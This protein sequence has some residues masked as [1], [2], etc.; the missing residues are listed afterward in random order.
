MRFDNDQ[1]STNGHVK[2]EEAYRTV[3]IV[4]E[5]VEPNADS[6]SALAGWCKAN[7]LR[8]QA[9]RTTAARSTSTLTLQQLAGNWALSKMKADDGSNAISS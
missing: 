7:G 8:E 4:S 9:E 5:N 6:H 3:P 2:T 1:L